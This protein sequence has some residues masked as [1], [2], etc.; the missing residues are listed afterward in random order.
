M[1]FKENTSY[2]EDKELEKIFSASIKLF[3]LGKFDF[4]RQGFEYVLKNSP[5]KNKKGFLSRVF[6]KASLR[7]EADHYLKKIL[8]QQ[9]RAEQ[10]EKKTERISQ[11]AKII[12]LG[13]LARI[14]KKIKTASRHP[15]VVGIDISDHSIE[16]LQ[17]DIDR[18]IQLHAR[19]ILEKGIVESAKIKDAERLGKIFQ[20]TLKEAGLDKLM[21]K[22]KSRI[23]GLFSFPESKAF[24]REFQFEDRENLP[25]KIRDKIKENIPFAFEELYWDHI[26]L[27]SQSGKIRVLVV[28][29]PEKAIDEYLY[30]FWTH[31]VDPVVFDIEAASIARALLPKGDRKQGTVIV[32]IGD[33][34]SIINIFNPKKD[35]N[36]SVS[37]FCAGNYFTQ[38]VAEKLGVTW[39]EAET[40]KQQ[41][42]FEKEPVSAVLQ[43]CSGALIKEIKNAL[44][45]HQDRFGFKAETIILAGGSVLLP[46]IREHFQKNFEEKVEIGNPLHNIR[47]GSFFP[48]EKKAALYANV[49]GLAMRG[50]EKDF[51]DGGIN[52]L[53]D[54]IKKQEKILQRER[55]RF[56]LYIAAYFLVIIVAFLAISLTLYRFGLIKFAI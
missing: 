16:I 28:V 12:Q 34:T 38:K 40:I 33:R 49:I 52:L 56:V 47:P 25:E 55:Q 45:Y 24:I 41:Y 42:G 8:Q 21:A 19:S 32:D 30:F 31:G 1:S 13:K 43:E 15:L 4:A 6:K 10:K 9:V 51:I 2:Q 35:L 23:K 27:D 39:Q 20:A 18:N 46:G 7:A 26:E 44:K 5:E 11:K 54:T 22:K 17:L 50:L 29:V 53:A 37:V 3:K 48:D 36:L 14:A